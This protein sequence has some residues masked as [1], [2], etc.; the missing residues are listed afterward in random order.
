ML[1]VVRLRTEYKENPIGMDEVH[2]RFAYQ[3]EGDSCFQRERR[4]KVADETGTVV[5]DTGWEETSRTI[6]IEYQ[7]LSLKPFTRYRWQVQAKD[8]NGIVS[9]PGRAFFETGF[10]G[11][12]WRGSW[13]ISSVE[14][15]VAVMRPVR[16]FRKDFTPSGK[17]KSAR[18]YAAALGVYSA[19]IN[20]KE[21]E[22]I[23]LAPGWSDYY[24]RVQYQAYDVTKMIRSGRNNALSFLYAE[25]WYGGTISRL[26]SEGKPTYD[27]RD[28]IR[29]ELH[30]VYQDG[31]KEI[32]ASDKTFWSVNMK[33]RG[34]SYICYSDI[35]MGESFVSD[36]LGYN[37]MLPGE[38]QRI[39]M[40]PNIKDG[41]YGWETVESHTADHLSMVWNAGAFV[42]HIQDLEPVSVTRRKNGNWIVD[43]GQNLV[44][45]E[46][47]TL[48]NPE[49][50]TC[51]TIR[52]GEMLQA[53]GSL[54]T[55][56]L[57]SAAATTTFRMQC[58]KKLEVYEPR[59]TFYGFR[60]LE[61]SGWPGRLAK[62]DI[63][64]RVI[65][66][67]LPVTGS[68]RCSDEMVNQ[69]YSN[70]LWGQ[71]GNFVDIPTDCPQR[72][73][74]F[75]WTGD[76]QVF[77]NMATYNMYAPE[78][79]TKWIDD[80]NSCQ[81]ENGV[82]PRFAPQ[83]FVKNPEPGC[84][85]WLDAA[86]ICP[87]IM[88]GKYA[89]TRLMEK[90]FGNMCR[91][92]DYQVEKTG[93]SFLVSH[94]RY[95]DWL[96]IGAPTPEEV[97]STTYLAGMNLL[98]SR[99]A[100]I[101]GREQDAEERFRNYQAAAGAFAEKY[102][103]KTGVLKVKTQTAALLA[104]SFGCVPEKYVK[105]TVD[106]LVHD[107]K[108]TRNLHLS[109]GFLGTPLL[110]KVLTQSGH[111][112][113]A[114]DLLLQKSYPSWLYPVTQGATTMWERWNTWTK[115]DGFGDVGMNSFN[116]YAYGAVGEWFFENI[117]GITC[118]GT[119]PA[120]AGFQTVRLAPQPGKRLK[121]AEAVYQSFSGE[122]RSAWKR[123]GKK[124]LWE[125]T[126][127]CNTV[128]EIVPPFGK[129]L[130]SF[131]GMTKHEDGTITVLPGSYKVVFPL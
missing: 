9:R 33:D 91:W 7:G 21:V 36:Y 57:R 3:L 96:N 27:L 74:R 97:I 11:T 79:F 65:H 103:T 40:V 28:M 82:Y 101:L 26:W 69:L 81:Q 45:R 51:I 125:F 66:S 31:S 129:E 39:D 14:N 44:G 86:L 76:T 77:C 47:I 30:I 35:Y 10:L 115:E 23:C 73:E 48:R 94:A 99:M 102:F 88:F 4:I 119:S 60:Y 121:E 43:F 55:A 5:W 130:P 89:D 29:A 13:L 87:W 114:Y 95:G 53:D 15:S 20:G 106:F 67:D 46:R 93:G 107:I 127:P 78:F 72:D 118:P 104:L 1:N 116:H 85:G 42:R 71:K 84:S 59:F 12:P 92:L 18:L 17:V 24:K 58:G 32:I 56:N 37:W 111:V 123:T 100:R 8:E 41:W 83:P 98:A 50:G 131:R 122:I 62:K 61:I 126:I 105:K 110:L 80:L 52:H 117:C 70:I 63:Q 49:A 120:T 2:P 64:A 90:Y 22:D 124:F 25:G 38:K 109:T 54:Y 75:G 108:I 6:Q 16:G 113:L 112:D 128:A 19:F 68:F 34:S